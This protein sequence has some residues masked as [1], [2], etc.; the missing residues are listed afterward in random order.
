MY[1]VLLGKQKSSMPYE[2]NGKSPN[3]LYI[4]Y[5][6]IC[7]VAKNPRERYYIQ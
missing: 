1:I 7:S 6:G 3:F 5:N 4:R 2:G